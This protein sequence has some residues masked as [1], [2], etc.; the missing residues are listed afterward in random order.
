MNAAVIKSPNHTVPS[1]LLTLKSERDLIGGPFAVTES[2]PDLFTTP[3][4]TLGVQG[5][6]AAELHDIRPPS[7]YLRLGL[8]LR[9]HDVLPKEEP[10]GP[11]VEEDDSAKLWFMNQLGDDACA[12]VAI[13]NV[14]PNLEE[15]GVGERLR[16]FRKETERMSSLV[17]RSSISLFIGYLSLE[18]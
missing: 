8:L 13:M 15:V 18:T 1:L 11:E 6:Q 12:S 2:E 7:S 14:L 16:E 17:W 3:V 9:Y 4:H 5:L 10:N